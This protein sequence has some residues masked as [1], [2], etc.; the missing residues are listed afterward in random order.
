MSENIEKEKE[1][2][3]NKSLMD[4]NRILFDQLERLNG[5]EHKPEELKIELEK[6]R[7]VANLSQT[8]INNAKVLLDAEKYYDV[9]SNTIKN[10]FSVIGDKGGNK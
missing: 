7:A 8:M 1:N 4:L 6:S 3:E 10:M 2:K 5:K 9:R